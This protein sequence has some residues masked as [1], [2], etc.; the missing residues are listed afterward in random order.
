[1]QKGNSLSLSGQ[2]RRNGKAMHTIP[3]HLHLQERDCLKAYRL[4][5]K[6][7]RRDEP[8][9]I[10]T[11]GIF[12]IPGLTKLALSRKALTSVGDHFL[13]HAFEPSLNLVLSDLQSVK[14][15]FGSKSNKWNEDSND[16]R[17]TWLGHAIR[18]GLA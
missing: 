8:I 10:R 5:A 11:C 13:Y 18:V 9:P 12:S 16:M 15:Y 14:P 2:C 1:M 6:T 17:V 3:S 4:T 7:S